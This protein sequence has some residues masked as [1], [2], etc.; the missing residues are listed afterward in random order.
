VVYIFLQKKKVEF[1]FDRNMETEAATHPLYEYMSLS[2]E[3][4][5]AYASLDSLTFA[6]RD[7][8]KKGVGIQAADL[9][10]REAM[11]HDDNILI[12]NYKYPVREE[13]EIL[14]ATNRFRF[15]HYGEKYFKA[16]L[17]DFDRLQKKANIYYDKYVQWLKDHKLHDNDSNRHRYLIYCRNT[18]KALT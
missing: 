2:S 8:E 12:S 1:I 11:K 10:A 13:M 18:E 16:Y 4:K 17:A 6:K 5:K 7:S 3:Y 14:M 9:V 15:S